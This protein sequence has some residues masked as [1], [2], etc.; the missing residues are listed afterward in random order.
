MQKAAICVALMLLGGLLLSGCAAAAQPV[1]GFLYSDVDGP[2]T[3]TS[4]SGE[5]EVKVG[6]AT[7]TSIL[8]WVATGDASIA[9]A[10]DSA[11]ITKIRNVDH[12]SQ[13]LLGII[14]SYTVIVYGW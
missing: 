14:A 8:G 2:V 3:A 9:T 4:N 1:T 6:E 7:C 11:G 12:H 10:M 5:G 13:S